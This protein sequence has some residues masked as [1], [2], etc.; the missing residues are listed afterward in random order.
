[1][2]LSG[3]GFCQGFRGLALAIGYL[4]QSW[5]HYLKVRSLSGREE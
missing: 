3:A 2:G 4:W 5:R 1:M